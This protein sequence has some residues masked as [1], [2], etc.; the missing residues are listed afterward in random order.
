MIYDEYAR[1]GIM[2]QIK[3]ECGANNISGKPLSYDDVINR[4]NM[5]HKHKR[6]A[7]T[8]YCYNE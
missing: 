7:L 3:E 5:I 2:N 6:T 8:R 1:E 4:E